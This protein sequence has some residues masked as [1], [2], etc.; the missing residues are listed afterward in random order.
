[1]WYDLISGLGGSTG[2]G[3]FG[4]FCGSVGATDRL[5]GIERSAN[6][7]LDAQFSG[8]T[9]VESYKSIGSFKWKISNF[10]ICSSNTL[11]N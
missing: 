8:S 4:E 7:D 5:G 11:S 3:F 10:E 2:V 6:E 1:M 9:L